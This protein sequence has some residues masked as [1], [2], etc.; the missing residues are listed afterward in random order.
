MVETRL[1]D[2]KAF[3]EQMRARLAGDVAAFIARTGVTPGL[4]VVLV[5]TDPASAVYVRN[6]NK[7]TV[8]AGMASIEHALPAETTEDALLA[9][10]DALNAD[11]D[12]HGIL[13]Q[14]PLPDHIDTQKVL[15]AIDPA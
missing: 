5:G 4:A 14:L 7:Q 9:L 2:G 1:I 15:A 11:P 12:V 8:E 13:V 10:I 3:A 6:K